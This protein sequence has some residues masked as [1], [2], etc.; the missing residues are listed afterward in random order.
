M[1]NTS[2]TKFTFNGGNTNIREVN[3]GIVINQPS[4]LPHP[5]KRA[6]GI[7]VV[8][9]KAVESTAVA[10]VFGLTAKPDD[11]TGQRF[12]MGEVDAADGPAPLVAARTLQQG[13]RSIM[14]TLEKL[15]DAWNPAIFVIVGVGGA[16]YEKLRI[17][18]VV[19]ADRVF[20]YDLRREAADGMHYRGEGW[21]AP[22]AI[23]H[24]MNSFFDDYGE[25]PHF[26]SAGGQFRVFSGPIGSGDAV[27]TDA[28]S[29]IRTYLQTV[30]EKVLAVDT[31]SGGLV[32][33][34][35]EAPPPQ[36]DWLV[37]RGIS[38]HA[39]QKKNEKR[40]PL[41]ARNAATTLQ[42]LIPHLRAG[43]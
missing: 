41:A 27:I 4:P 33:F 1:N 7:G 16:I 40:Q 21:P 6:R 37:V 14:P 22:A 9:I 29:R 36:P 10:D 34:C 3:S 23:T 25:M 20:Y 31:E 2:N 17:G 43:A 26:K 38:D 19:V 5:V 42:Q 12:Y 8:T 18:D 13:N 11:A 30:N 32:Q 39:D 35:H 15:R 28:D 24:A